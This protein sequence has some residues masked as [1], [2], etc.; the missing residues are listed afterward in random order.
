MN[1]ILEQRL[2]RCSNI[3]F[4]QAPSP[5]PPHTL[6]HVGSH[7]RAR[8]RIHTH[9]YNKYCFYTSTCQATVADVA[10]SL[11]CIARYRIMLGIMGSLPA[12]A[13]ASINATLSVHCRMA[14]WILFYCSQNNYNFFLF[15]L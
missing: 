7:A 8:A 3:S 11:H 5:S 6:P 4:T 1:D 14:F 2:R 9:F 15:K 10:R 12:A 13:A